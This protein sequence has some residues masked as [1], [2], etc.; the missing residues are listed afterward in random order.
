MARQNF[1]S[2]SVP[3]VELDQ[4]AREARLR[5]VRVE[6]LLVR[7]VRRRR[8]QLVRLSFSRLF[9]EPKVDRTEGSLTHSPEGCMPEIDSAWLQARGALACSPAGVPA[10]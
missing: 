5:L 10:R 4:R 2:N 9:S 1:C 3:R 8:F 6:R 7:R